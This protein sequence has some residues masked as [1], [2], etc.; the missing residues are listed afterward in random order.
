MYKWYS[1]TEL[2][3]RSLHISNLAPQVLSGEVD[4]ISPVLPRL[5]MSV[6]LCKQ[7]PVF[8]K[9]KDQ[10]FLFFWYVGFKARELDMYIF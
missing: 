7:S 9:W 10:K 2:T 4:N 8:L 5:Q 3:Y 1:K 6:T